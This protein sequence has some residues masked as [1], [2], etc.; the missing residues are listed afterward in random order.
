MAKEF[1]RNQPTSELKA[2]TARSRE[3]VAG[4]LRGLRYELDFPRKFR[5]SFRRQTVAWI[6]AIVV[7][8]TLIAVLPVRKKKVY[9]DAK[10]GRKT[11]RNLLEAGFALGVLKIAA[12]L[13]RPAI[14][15]FITKKMLGYPGPER[16]ARKW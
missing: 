3:R 2:E 7:V 14:T 9:I 13:L 8:G 16:S 12:S 5:H 1:R 10:S 4:D 6:T 15:S 11:K